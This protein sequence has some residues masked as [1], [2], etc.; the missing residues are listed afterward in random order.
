[1]SKHTPGPWE[2]HYRTRIMAD[3]KVVGISGTSMLG[4]NKYKTG[5]WIDETEANARLIASAP[6]LL[7][8]CE[9]LV[10]WYRVNEPGLGTPPE[11]GKAEQAIAKAKGEAD[12]N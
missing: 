4:W 10:S 5:E 11:V 3:K 6:D 7:A 8:A 9:A 1:M 2:V 12:D